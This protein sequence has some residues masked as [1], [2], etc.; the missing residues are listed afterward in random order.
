MLFR[1]LVGVAMGIVR[2][3]WC[4]YFKFRSFRMWFCCRFLQVHW[5]AGPDSVTPRAN[6]E[7]GFWP[8][9]GLMTKLDHKIR[10]LQ[11]L[12]VN[13]L[14]GTVGGWYRTLLHHSRTYLSRLES[15]WEEA[16]CPPLLPL[17]PVPE[18]PLPVPADWRFPER[19]FSTAARFPVRAASRS[20]CSFPISNPKESG[21]DAG[22]RGKQGRL[23]AWVKF[24]SDPPFFLS[25]PPQ[26]ISHYCRS[27]GEETK[28]PPAD[29]SVY[30]DPRCRWRKSLVGG[31]VPASS[32]LP[33]TS[34]PSSV[35]HFLETTLF[36]CTYKSTP[37]PP[38]KLL[39]KKVDGYKQYGAPA[40]KLALLIPITHWNNIEI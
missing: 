30:P 19:S 23:T 37:A 9:P 14:V 33:L 16:P 8:A 10:W 5:P 39:Y 11:Q 22:K 13:H 24:L 32:K 27:F 29:G 34:P 35:R 4:P 21:E 7:A 12:L 18:N 31:T 3:G 38:P 2:L 25:P 1:R 40:Q 20:S 26:V 28:A 6:K 36:F 15:G 17:P